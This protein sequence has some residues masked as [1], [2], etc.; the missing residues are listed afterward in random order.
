M[1][2]RTALRL[3]LEAR[4]ETVKSFAEGLSVTPQFIGQVCDRGG[5]SRRVEEAIN[6]VLAEQTPTVRR[7]LA[8]YERLAQAA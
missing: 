8:R 3:A 5:I 6:K 7:S 2:K 4:G 1:T